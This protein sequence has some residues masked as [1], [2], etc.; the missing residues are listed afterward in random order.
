M[1]ILGLI[2]FP[3]HYNFRTYALDLGYSLQLLDSHLRGNLFPKC[4]STAEFSPDSRHSCVDPHVAPSVILAV[5]FY[6]LGGAWGVLIHQWLFIGGMAIG[7]FVYAYYRTGLWPAGLW[8]MIHFFGM[9]GITSLLAYDWHGEIN[10]IVWVPWF[11]YALEAGNPWLFFLGWIFFI[12]GKATLTLWGM[13]MAV[14]LMIIYRK[15]FQRRWLLIA[16]CISLAWFF[17]GYYVYK[18]DS[19]SISRM[20]ALFSYLGAR[21][22]LAV[23]QGQ[24]PSPEYS[25]AAIART[26]IS[27]PQLVWT[28]LLESPHPEAVGVKAELHWSVLWSGGWS[29]LWK[30]VALV[31]LLPV[32]IYKLL[33]ESYLIWGTLYQYSIE[34]AA[35]LPIAV[36]WAAERWKGHYTFWLA[37]AAGALGAHIM[38]L[39][40]LSARYSLWY[41]GDHYRWYRIYHYTSRYCYPKIHEG[42]R[43]IPRDA[44][45]AASSRLLPHIPPREKYYILP[46]HTP[47]DYVAMLQYDPNP[48]P[49]SPKDYQ[50]HID[51]LSRSPEWEKIWDREGLLIFK[52]K[53]SPLTQAP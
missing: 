5:P 3:N 44:S 19:R 34:F 20:Q 13:W 48:W 37:L 40:L 12:G 8:T 14:V 41:Q 7:F 33:A 2:T 9:W 42:L 43:L 47:V 17:I 36:L 52:R 1:T 10:G 21:N 4:L 32:Y 22:P 31:L 11:L 50:K 53:K 27:R 15:P 46:L 28:L 45:V 38:N 24:A 18:P 6:A 35:I 51:S 16:A 29:F 49:L 30:P 26:I 25:L 23:M 39:S